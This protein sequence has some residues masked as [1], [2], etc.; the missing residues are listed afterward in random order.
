MSIFDI[1]K[2]QET[3]DAFVAAKAKSL[4]YKEEELAAIKE[5]V[6]GG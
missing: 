4:K 5:Y 2:Q 1:A 3:R 6:L